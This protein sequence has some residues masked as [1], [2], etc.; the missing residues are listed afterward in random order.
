MLLQMTEVER[1]GYSTLK[2]KKTSMH[3]DVRYVPLSLIFACYILLDF[4]CRDPLPCIPSF[5]TGMFTPCFCRVEVSSLFDVAIEFHS[6]EIALAG[7]FGILK[8][9]GMLRESENF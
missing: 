4:L 5:S 2:D 7:D 1:W 6:L 8:S 9:L 3:H